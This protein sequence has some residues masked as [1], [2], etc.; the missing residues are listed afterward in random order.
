MIFCMLFFFSHFFLVLWQPACCTSSVINSSANNA[1]EED[2]GNMLIVDDLD[3]DRVVKILECD[4]SVQRM[5]QNTEPSHISMMFICGTRLLTHCARHFGSLDDGE[6][7][8]QTL[9]KHI[10]LMRRFAIDRGKRILFEVLHDRIHLDTKRAEPRRSYCFYAAS[11]GRT[12]PKYF[13]KQH[14]KLSI[15]AYSKLVDLN[16]GLPGI[17]ASSATDYLHL[18]VVWCKLLKQ[19]KKTKSL[20]TSLILSMNMTDIERETAMYIF[21]S[22]Q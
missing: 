16:K 7:Y 21:N 11:M 18:F 10:V 14:P 12:P 13:M 20:F 2:M 15:K 17:M 8:F 4:A 19:R 6:D 22:P 3:F 1:E 9:K 5:P